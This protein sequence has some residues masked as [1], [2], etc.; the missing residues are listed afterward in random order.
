MEIQVIS[1]FFFEESAVTG[2]TFLVMMESI[3]SRH[4]PVRKVFQ[5]YG[6]QPHLFRRVH[7]FLDSEFP[8]RWIGRGEPIP[9]PPR[10]PI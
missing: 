5:F 10:S 8:G 2:G 1:S 6:A 4:V 3:A 7:A 9:W